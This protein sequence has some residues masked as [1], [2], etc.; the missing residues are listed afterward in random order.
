MNGS[1]SLEAIVNHDRMDPRA[2]DRVSGPTWRKMRPLFDQV[3]G[4]LLSLSATAPGELTTIYV[5]F[6][7]Q[8][9]RPQ[10]YGVLW[11]KKASQMVLGLAIPDEATPPCFTPPP[12][13]YV[14]KG[15]KKYVAIHENDEIAPDLTD[16]VQ[17]AYAYVAGTG[18]E[19]GGA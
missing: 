10:P 4:L 1:C 3:T 18:Q 13:G 7:D 12:R 5:K 6:L 11:I 14:Y 8:E 19:F 16:W 15:L 2:L 9:T 17:V